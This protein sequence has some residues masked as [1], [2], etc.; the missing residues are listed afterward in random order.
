V[1]AWWTDGPA[2]G[3][4]H[5]VLGIGNCGIYRDDYGVRM[6]DTV[7]VADSGPLSLTRYPKT[8]VA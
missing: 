5:E 3:G 7:W 6:E 1:T 2:G 4:E 8:V